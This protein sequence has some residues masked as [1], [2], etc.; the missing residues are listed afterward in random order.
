MTKEKAT[1]PGTMAHQGGMDYALGWAKETHNMGWLIT[2]NNSRSSQ[3]QAGRSYVRLNL[4]AT[5]LGV[6]MHPVSQV[7]QEYPEMDALQRNFNQTIGIQRDQRVQMFF[8][9]GYQEQVP[10]SPR[11]R[12]ADILRS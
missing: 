5:K 6:S 8:R 7:L 4:L 2:E 10:P 11:R 9:I 12:L 1:T 3:V